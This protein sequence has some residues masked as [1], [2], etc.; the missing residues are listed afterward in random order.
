M[1]ETWKIAIAC[2]VGG[3]I[4]YLAA[5][6]FTPQHAWLGVFAGLSAGYFAYEF[7]EVLRAIPVAFRRATETMKCVF[8]VGYDLCACLWAS[9]P[10]ALD[11][12]V[13]TPRPIFY[14]ALIPSSLIMRY[15]LLALEPPSSHAKAGGSTVLDVLLP[16]GVGVMMFSALVYQILRVIVGVGMTDEERGRHIDS[17]R[18]ISYSRFAHWLLVGVCRIFLFC[19]WGLWVQIFKITVFAVGLCA[20]FVWMLFKLIHSHK[21]VLCAIDG[22]IGGVI[23]FLCFHSQNASVPEH[24]LLAAFGGLIGAA[25]GV[26]N[27]EIISIRLLKVNVASKSV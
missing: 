23:S 15:V 22:T 14:T 6:L 4:C 3:F 9:A 1:R 13:F 26:L 24:V 20:V 17:F 2:F 19:I 16:T 12:F 11:R 27:W 7:R 25:W 8:S 5:A 21:R 10:A 18:D